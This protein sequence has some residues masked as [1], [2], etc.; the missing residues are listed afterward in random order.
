[1]RRRSRILD[2][3]AEQCL[4]ESDAVCDQRLHHGE[5]RFAGEDGRGLKSRA[6]GRS[7][8]QG[9]AA[10]ATASRSTHS[11]RSACRATL[12]QPASSRAPSSRSIFAPACGR[13]ISAPRSAARR[14]IKDR[15]TGAKLRQH[16]GRQSVVNISQGYRQVGVSASSCAP[17]RTGGCQPGAPTSSRHHTASAISFGANE[18]RPGEGPCRRRRSTSAPASTDSLDA[19]LIEGAK[20]PMRGASLRGR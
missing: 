6:G 11:G 15:A 18:Q 17:A 4:V 9:C 8:R 7:S 13:R 5:L 1:M 10:S 16:F 14:P 20:G 2:R 12:R 19:P 3:A